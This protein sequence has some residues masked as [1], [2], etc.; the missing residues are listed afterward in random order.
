MDMDVY[1]RKYENTQVVMEGNDPF[2]EKML[3]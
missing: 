1:Y 2:F 3:C